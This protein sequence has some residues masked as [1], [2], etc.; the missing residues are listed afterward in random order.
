MLLI[1]NYKLYVFKGSKHGAP[2]P[3]YHLCLA[4]AYSAPFVISF[5][6]GKTAVQ[7]SHPVAESSPESVHCLRGKGYFRNQHYGCASLI[8]G[9]C[10]GLHIYFR[11]AGT[12]YAMQQKFSPAPFHGIGNGSQRPFL[13]FRQGKRL[14]FEYIPV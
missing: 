10:Y 13:L 2:C 14:C 8:Q 11:F 1:H 5:A 7:H 12:C 4:Q 3:Q 9:F 6:G